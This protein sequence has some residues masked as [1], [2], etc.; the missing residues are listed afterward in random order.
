MEKDLFRWPFSWQRQLR[1]DNGDR[2]SY[3]AGDVFESAI[4]SEDEKKKN[5]LAR[6][7]A[8]LYEKAA[9]CYEKAGLG[10]AARNCILCA[11]ESWGLAEDDD[12]ANECDR[13]AEKINTYWEEEIDEITE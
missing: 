9:S 1:I 10:L 5:R 8:R 13:L 7:A 12:L 3:K 6:K 11:S 2:I 4:Y